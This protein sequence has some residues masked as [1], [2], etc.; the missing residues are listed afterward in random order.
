MLDNY[1]NIYD[2][3]IEGIPSEFV[4]ENACNVDYEDERWLDTDLPNICV[5]NYGR[6]YNV[7]TK[8]FLTPTHGDSQGHKAIKTKTKQAYAH[9]E[10]AKAF[11]PNP[12]NLPIV[13][14]L[15]DDRSN[16]VIENL[17][18]GTQKDNHN[19]AVRNGTYRPITD[20]DRKKGIE[21]T[22]K[23]VKLT[24]IKTGEVVY[25]MSTGEAARLIGSHQSN[26][27]KVINK[28][29]QHTKGY[30]AEYISKE[31]FYEKTH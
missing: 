23:P 6:F 12:D 4:T 25:A 11:I 21:K 16:N 5:S 22:S 2:W 30:T 28:E 14:H 8:R 26:V 3:P 1:L 29:R 10:I 19:D 24:N 13:R 27:W 17:A 31:E 7:K 9:R 18:W 20:M 15:D